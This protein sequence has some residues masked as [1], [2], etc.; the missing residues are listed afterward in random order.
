[1]L[2]RIMLAAVMAAG[3]ASAQPGG[4]GMGEGMG[5]AG[6]MGRGGRGGDRMGEGMGGAGI[7][8]RRQSRLDMLA[9]KLKLKSDQKSEVE[10]ILS[11][12]MEKAGP[13]RD[14]LTQARRALAEAMLSKA[15]DDEIKKSL[16]G[17]A[18]VSAQMTGIEADAFVKIYALLKPNQQG[19]AAQA[20]ELMAGVFSGGG[21][22]GN[23]GRRGNRGGGE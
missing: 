18:T 15:S 22:G 21:G 4:N 23:V 20:F 7:A 13:V 10:K 5:G 11:A 2:V 19:K 3:L 12:S 6:A 14:Q 16:D 8:P 1:M 17:Y 9:D